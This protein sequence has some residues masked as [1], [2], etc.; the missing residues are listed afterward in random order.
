V[1]VAVGGH[2]RPW[3]QRNFRIHGGFATSRSPVGSADQ[4]FSE[5]HLSSWSVG[6]SG[7]VA[8]LHFAVGLNSRVGATTDVLVRNL[9]SAEALRTKVDVGSRALVYSLGYQF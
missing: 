2:F 6:V 9:L 7:T 3:R 1:N 5:A 8:R 4:V